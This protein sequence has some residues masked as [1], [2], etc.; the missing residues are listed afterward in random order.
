MYENK[1]RFRPFLYTAFDND[2]SFSA[3]STTVKTLVFGETK[4]LHDGH[5]LGGNTSSCEIH[6]I[7]LS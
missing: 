2:V 1:Q 7:T 4:V 6:A 3:F 5:S